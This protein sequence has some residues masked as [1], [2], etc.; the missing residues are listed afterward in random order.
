[1]VRTLEEKIAE[2]ILLLDVQGICSFADYFIICS[3]SS[4]RML[5]ALAEAVME[6]A[7]KEFHARARSRG[8]SES[9]W[10]LVD[11]GAVIVHMLSPDRREYYDLEGFWKEAKVLVH[12]Q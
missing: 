2:E 4:E 1:M 6:T 9:G 10:I 8:R 5:N 12:I 3:G 11:T 7:H